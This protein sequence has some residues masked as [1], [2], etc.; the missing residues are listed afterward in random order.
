M[1]AS[2]RFINLLMALALA[3]GAVVTAAP[4]PVQA[5]S[6]SLVISQFQVAGGTAADEFIEIHN[7]S[8]S[9]ID[10]NGYKVVYR[11]ASG[12]SDVTLL[13][14][15]AST[16]IPAG[17]YYLIAANPG[18]DGTTTADITY[19]HSGTGALSG[20]SGGLAIRD[21]SN[22]IVDSVGYG[23][24]TN[25]F[26]ETTPTPAPAANNSKSRLNSGCTDTDNNNND[27]AVTSPSAPRNSTTAAFSCVADTPPSVTGTVPTTGAT[28]VAPD[29]NISITFSEAVTLSAGW[30]TISC[31]TSG[32]HT[33]T[34]DESADPVIVL[35][36]AIDFGYSELCTVTLEADFIVDEDGTIDNMAADYSWS[37]TTSG[38]DADPSVT[39]TT[40]ATGATGVAANADIIIDFSEPVTIAPD[41][42]FD[43][44]CSISGDHAGA[45]TGGPTS[46]TFN[47][48]A[49]FLPG[50]TCTA[51]VQNDQVLD[52]DP[53]AQPMAADY[54]WTFTIAAATNV[55][56]DPYIPIHNIQGSGATSPLTGTVTTEGIVV[57]DYEGASPAL[58][59]FYLQS[60]TADSNPATSEGIFIYNNSNNSNVALGDMIRISGTVSE[61]RGQTQVTLASTPVLTLCGTGSVPTP[62]VVDLPDVADAAFSLEAY[63]GMLVTIPETLTVQQNY[64]QGRYGQVTLGAGG[65]VPQIHNVTKYTGTDPYY[66]F[67]RMIILDDASSGQNPNPISYYPNDDAMRA[68]DTVT[69][70]TGIVDQGPINTSTTSL[71]LPYNWYRLQPTAAPTFTRTNPRPATPPAVGGRIV[72]ASANVLNYFPTLDQTPYPS[73][74]PYG[75]SNTPR[76]ADSA[77]EFARQEPKIVAELATLNADVIGLM[78]IESWDGA[79]GG[80]GAP[81][82]L[83]DALNAYIGTP[84]LY[85]P[86]AD[87]ITGSFDPSTGG[88]TIQVAL[89]Y[90][91]TTVVPVGTA[92]SSDDPIFDRAPFAAEFEELVSGDQFV[93]VVNHFKS[94]GSCPSAGDP[95]ADQG[96]GQGCWNLKRRE[97][98]AALLT[99]INTNLVA[100]DPDVLVIGDLNS[101]GAEDPI[102][103]LIAGGMVN[104]VAG[105]VP[106]A[107][108][109]GY[110]FDGT[111]GYLDHALGTPSTT[112][113]ITDVSFWHINSDEPSVIDYNTEY[114]T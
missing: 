10:V 30:Y 1:K 110:V 114:K 42:F 83:C 82:A 15:S 38:S 27:F 61:Y 28:G 112:A 81:Q 34:V 106:E 73:G 43:I 111:A 54:V 91:T 5:V 8:G 88:D 71:V 63:E 53:P 16:I 59:G 100:L 50:E 86:V 13:T 44:F 109:Y 46:Y 32:A 89:I 72:V 60:L 74:S 52:Q 84:G 80:I 104:Q 64:F 93:V 17:G 18:Y 33:A 24:A 25:I 75:G 87:P 58:R 23:S 29:A 55:C 20:S 22:N 49:D 70:V 108:R 97:Q 85:A 65:R 56:G 37:F 67:T 11:S 51:T 105:F 101:Y 6:T 79:A 76:G 68:G 96:D 19:T 69:G 92:V 14:F 77:A 9:A 2:F 41:S 3:I 36:P 48:T 4:Q 7:V 12:T 95:N 31:A 102:A 107:E 39:A 40:P 90:K 94:K 57:A 47:P 103:D 66:Q 21:S 45:T 26:V 62:V 98:A 99:L 35:N 78:E 113:Q